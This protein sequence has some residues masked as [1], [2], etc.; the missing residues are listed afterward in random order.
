MSDS[1]R[2]YVET[3]GLQVKGATIAKDTGGSSLGGVSNTVDSSEMIESSNLSEDLDSSASSGDKTSTTFSPVHKSQKN[4]N[5][6]SQSQHGL[7]H[8]SELEEE[9][10]EEEE[11]DD[12]EKKK[13]E[14]VSMC[15]FHSQLSRIF[16]SYLTTSLSNLII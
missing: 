16:I 5:S 3:K 15:M 9:E 14:K 10:E 4:K 11:D 1:K 7:H 2:P 13:K 6:S 12:D 8:E